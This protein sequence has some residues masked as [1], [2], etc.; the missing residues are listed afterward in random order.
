[1]RKIFIAINILFAVSVTAQQSN[2]SKDIATTIMQTWKDSFAL[3]GKSIKW[4]YDMGVVLKGIE[5]VWLSTGD[6][7]YYNYIQKQV[8]AYVKEDG[9]IKT[10]K[11]EDFNLDNVNNG[12]ILLLLYRVT[13]KEKYLKAAKQLWQQLQLQPRTKEG[14]FWHKKIYPNQQW[15]DGL[16]MEAPFYAEYAWLSH[17]DSVFTDIANQFILAEKNTR[18]SETGLLK[19]AY[20]ES[21]QMK[22]SDP[23][24][25]QSPLCWARAMGWYGAALVDA[26]EYFPTNHT[27]R[28]ALIAIL[29][30]YILAIKQQQDLNSGLWKD[31]LNYKGPNANKNYFEASASSQFVYTI[32][33]AVRLGY[34][35]SANLSVAQKGFSGLQKQFVKKESGL[36]NF[37]GTVKVSGL[38]GNPYRD[39]SFDYYMSEPVIVNDPKGIGAFL[40]A[41]NEMELS[42][43]QSVAKGKRVVMDNYFNRETK[44]DAFGNKI[45]FH[46]KWQEKDNGGYYF[47]NHIVNSFGATTSL[48]DEAPTKA[49]LQNAA[50]YF[51]IDPDWPKENKNPNYIKEEHINALYDYVKNGGVL[52]LMANDSNNVEF[53]NYNKL[54]ERFGIHW[55]ENM[56]HD[57]IDNQFEQ[58][59]LIMQ[60]GNPIFKANRKVFVKQLCTQEI[61]LP[62]T[63]VYTENKEV[64]MSVAKVGKGLVFAVGDPW[65]YNEYLDGRKLPAQ[66]ENYSAAQELIRYLLKNAK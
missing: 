4:T 31:V 29:N 15:L 48:L 19:H 13:L 24:T 43:S 9:S 2:L 1:M 62:A 41:C 46:Y 20:D 37:Y 8:D 7:T 59:A 56:R 64:I 47:M 57:V 63:A 30:R 3:D 27:L 42:A 36:T 49:N 28:P 66:Y 25:G 60:K 53:V 39:G 44:E 50:V 54:A 14:A 5:G 58:G 11:Q 34:T 33:K 55:Y 40:M 51:L 12:K 32:A 61:K 45:V 10:Y 23:S 52:V 38:G 65:F 22:W 16:Y 6:A 17:T 21:K 35:S 18:D 26:L